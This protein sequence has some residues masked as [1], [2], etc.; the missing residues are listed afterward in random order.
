LDTYKGIARGLGVPLLDVLQQAGEI[1][2]PLQPATDGESELLY[3][4]RQ[5]PGQ[6]RRAMVSTMHHL[7]EQGVQCA[8]WGD[9]DADDV[10]APVWRAQM[11]AFWDVLE[12]ASQEERDA[13]ENLIR[14]I[15][16]ER[17]KRNGSPPVSNNEV[18]TGNEK[19]QRIQRT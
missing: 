16:K 3:L 7:V 9:D 6:V 18:K 11:D 8:P 1:P 15:R 4:F 12:L 2:L 14:V 10:D 5:L 13:I 19:V 17:E